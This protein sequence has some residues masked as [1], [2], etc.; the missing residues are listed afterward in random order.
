MF[1][2]GVLLLIIGVFWRV[3]N[4][5]RQLI[6]TCVNKLATRKSD[7]YAGLVKTLTLLTMKNLKNALFCPVFGW[8]DKCTRKSKTNRIRKMQI[9]KETKEEL[10]KIAD[11]MC[12]S[13][14]KLVNS[15]LKDYLIKLQR[16]TEK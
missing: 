2:Y 3:L 11:K 5:F 14:T 16:A 4:P 13:Y 1:K 10:K 9:D 8:H 6:D 12:I 7:T 15:I